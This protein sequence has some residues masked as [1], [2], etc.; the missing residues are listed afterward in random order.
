MLKMWCV[1][2][3]QVFVLDSWLGVSSSIGWCFVL[4]LLVDG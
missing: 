4:L 1:V 2:A 3:F